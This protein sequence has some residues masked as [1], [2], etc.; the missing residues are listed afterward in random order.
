MV[1]FLRHRRRRGFLQPCF[2]GSHQSSATSLWRTSRARRQMQISSRCN[3]RGHETGAFRRVLEHLLFFRDVLLGHTRAIQFY[4]Y[5]HFI[6]RIKIEDFCLKSFTLHSKTKKKRTLLLVIHRKAIDDSNHNMREKETWKIDKICVTI[7]HGLLQAR[8]PHCTF[9]NRIYDDFSL[10]PISLF[11][12]LPALDFNIY[13]NH[14]AGVMFIKSSFAAMLRSPRFSTFSSLSTEIFVAY[15]WTSVLEADL[16]PT[17][18]Q[19]ST[20]SL[21]ST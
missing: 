9:H 18:S 13:V 16:S 8:S 6:R 2:D 12:Q 3:N 4:K 14:C 7:F 1:W 15:L 5:K 10:L 17:S 21:L 20:F 19:A 11:A